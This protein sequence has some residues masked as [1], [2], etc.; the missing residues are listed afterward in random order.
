MA[1]IEKKR[2]RKEPETA[3]NK[4]LKA[5][6]RPTV[7]VRPG[8]KD[9]TVA[10]ETLPWHEVPFPGN[11]HDA[12]GFFGLE[13]ISDVEVNRD[14]GK[15]EYKVKRRKLDTSAK[16][17]A[18]NKSGLDT[19]N[20]ETDE[21]WGGFETPDGGKNRSTNVIDPQNTTKKDKAK[22]RDRQRKQ[23]TKGPSRKA[24]GSTARNTFESLEEMREDTDDGEEYGDV[25]AWESLH[26]SPET[27]SS[28][29]R[30][31]FKSPT[32]IQA[33]AIPHILDG[34]D[35]ICKAPTGSGK[36]L[37]FGIP[38]L[39]H[40]L[41]KRLQE[42]MPNSKISKGKGYQPIALILSP[43]R[44]L[45]H[46]LSAHL[47]DL[48]TDVNIATLTGGLSMH[49]QQ[50]LLANAAIVIATPGRLWEVM[51]SNTQLTDS[52]KRV[53]FLILDEADRLLSSGH[54]QEVEEIL[55]TLDRSKATDGGVEEGEE[56]KNSPTSQHRQTLVFSATFDK[57]LQ[58]KLAGKSRVAMN[59]AL[60]GQ[61]S[62]E[63]L[64]R[65]LNFR[66]EKPKFIDVNP[67]SQM[68]TGLKEGLVECA[69]TEKVR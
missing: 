24:E 44:E 46:Q 69:G 59:G 66:E 16:K 9:E 25:S 42:N 55:N 7:Q 65:K 64:L 48:C 49:K 1:L 35:A 10:L 22:D 41:K 2:R 11:F 47:T 33:S 23:S 36:T 30:S 28:I 21:E 68:A 12:E 50:R 19:E 43:T 5:S 60:H 61:Q 63:Y 3:S 58:Q 54:F 6:H 34:H 8:N 15:V 27:L 40:C 14:V 38:I 56:G 62:M 18:G 57:D 26:V 39:E 4:K 37:G 52:L 51:S 20:E 17:N 31:K 53:H 13:E 67:I 29:A 45:A 32:P